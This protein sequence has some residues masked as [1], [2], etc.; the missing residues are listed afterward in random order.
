MTDDQGDLIK[1]S[2]DRKVI[3]RVEIFRSKNVTATNLPNPELH[4][5]KPESVF[6]L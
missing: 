2:N 6:M 4:L 3:V 1:Q 5:K